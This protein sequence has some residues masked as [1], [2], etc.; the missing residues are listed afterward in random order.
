MGVPHAAA[1]SAI[2]ISLAPENTM[3]EVKK[4][5]GIVKE[6]MPKLYEVMR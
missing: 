4:F 6:T 2:R 3:E 1:A 5:E